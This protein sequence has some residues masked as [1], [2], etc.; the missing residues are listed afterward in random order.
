MGPPP[1]WTP[2]QVSLRQPAHSPGMDQPVLKAPWHNGS[3]KNPVLYCSQKQLY[4]FPGAPPRQ[5]K[6][7]CRCTSPQ[8][9]V[10]LFFP[11]PPGQPASHSRTTGAGR[12]LEGRLRHLLHRAVVPSTSTTYGAGIRKY[13]AFCTQFNLN[14]LPVSKHTIN[15]FAAYLSQVLQANTI[16]VYLAAVTHLHLTRG[17]S[18]PAQNNPTLNLAIRGMQRS[19]GPAHLRPKRLPLTIGM[20]EQLLRLLNSDPLSNHDK[21]MLK[22]AL[23]IVFFL[24]S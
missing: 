22:A 11:C 1:G 24:G 3:P 15:L 6:L 16:Q 8:S 4:S 5:T 20:L 9:N 12:A 17:F 19:Q 10:T 21:L 14:P 7:H 23:T 13:Y 18:S 2:H